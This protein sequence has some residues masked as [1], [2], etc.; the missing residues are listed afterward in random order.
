[1]AEC[2]S[3]ALRLSKS[4]SIK[5]AISRAKSGEARSASINK[6]LLEAVINRQLDVWEREFLDKKNWISDEEFREWKE[7]LARENLGY[8]HQRMN[9]AVHDVLY[10]LVPP[11]A[12][13]A[14]RGT[15]ANEHASYN[16]I[17]KEF[18]DRYTWAEVLPY[19][20]RINRGA[21]EAMRKH[22]L[23]D[24]YV[25]KHPDASIIGY[26]TGHDIRKILKNG[27]KY[28]GQVNSKPAKHFLSAVNHIKEFLIHSQTYFTG[29]QAVGAME[30]WLA[31]F[32]AHD[33][34][35]YNGVKQALEILYYELN[36]PWRVAG[37]SPF[38]NNTIYWLADKSI[39]EQMAIID[40]KETG[41]KLED[42]EKEVDMV[43][44][45]IFEIEK[46]GDAVGSPFTYPIQNVMMT[47]QLIKWIEADP[48]RF[49]NFYLAA[50]MQ[51][52]QYF[53]NAIVGTKNGLNEDAFI[54]PDV[55]QAMCFHK[56]DKIL[57]KDK[58]GRVDYMTFEEVFERFAGEPDPNDG[59]G[60]WFLPKEEFYALSM[61]KFTGKLRWRKVVAIRR[62]RPKD[63]KVYR[64][65]LANGSF[66]RVDAEHLIS[67][68]EGDKMKTMYAKEFYKYFKEAKPVLYIPVVRTE[69]LPQEIKDPIEKHM[70]TLNIRFDLHKEK[71]FGDTFLVQVKDVIVQEYDDWVYDVEVDD[72]TYTK[73]N[74]DLPIIVVNAGSLAR[75]C[76]R[77]LWSKVDAKNRTM[78]RAI[79][80][81]ADE[82]GSKGIVTLNLP[83]FAIECKGDEQCYL[84]RIEQE[85]RGA[86]LEWLKFIHKWYLWLRW[87]AMP[88]VF[89]F[90]NFYQ[91]YYIWRDVFN[92]TF[93][94][95]GMTDAAHILADEEWTV[96][97]SED[98]GAL[99]KLV[100][101]YVKPAIVKMKEV[102]LE[103]KDEIKDELG[104]NEGLSFE[105]VPDSFVNVEEVPAETAGSKLLLKDLQRFGREALERY[106][107]LTT[108]EELG[109]PPTYINTVV[110]YYAEL[111]IDIVAELEGYVQRDF[112]GG[113]M[114]HFRFAD[115][116]K[117]PEIVAKIV[118]RILSH[119][120]INFSITP[121]V[122]TA[123][124]CFTRIVGWMVKISNFSDYRKAEFS[125]RV[126]YDAE[127]GEMYRFTPD[128]KK[129]RWKRSDIDPFAHIL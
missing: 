46:E 117:D 48:E 100:R 126:Y 54:D 65:E 124:G 12:S 87:R 78:A 119:G 9:I 106:V 113:V 110:P 63:N 36:H 91:P 69:N 89:K 28:T 3:M 127:T 13:A 80:G 40:G 16:L 93:G 94:A 42:F 68:F 104:L 82:T 26:C 47:N 6:K 103:L 99:R 107:N 96:W 76:C 75:D 22:A 4:R 7:K 108:M 64:I 21:F 62:A 118:K 98:Y 129:V 59:S 49:E 122:C 32:V 112:T 56:D 53:E 58:E 115:R 57:I 18:A 79:F 11:L 8:D 14:R 1:M 45:A 51:G 77:G 71:T 29:A 81:I 27:L 88:D 128:G 102:S 67:F 121:R 109:L 116:V 74:G 114:H 97:L 66:V 2:G 120:V 111:P 83:R 85:M 33:G 73:R 70:R 39:Q 72:E 23:G 41:D 17:I 25:H 101:D 43:F 10:E 20:Y 90:I 84:E 19:I 24:F 52:A 92:L 35:D 15:N 61:D 86:A 125:T 30:M 55:V 37:Q 44:R 31:P 50:G 95:V 5:S 105:N 34:L 123:E 60:E 38:T